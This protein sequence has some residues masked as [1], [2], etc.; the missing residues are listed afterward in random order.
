MSELHAESPAW[1]PLG[2]GVLFIF[3]FYLL[4]VLWWCFE[5]IT[6]LKLRHIVLALEVLC[7]EKNWKSHRLHFHGLAPST[8]LH[9]FPQMT[10]MLV[11][12]TEIWCRSIVMI[13]WIAH[14]NIHPCMNSLNPNT[15]RPWK[16]LWDCCTSF[17][18]KR[19]C[20][21][22][23]EPP[24]LPRE[25]RQQ[26]GAESEYEEEAGTQGLDNSVLSVASFAEPRIKTGDFPPFIPN[27]SRFCP[28]WETA[29][30]WTHLGGLARVP[31]CCPMQIT[32]PQFP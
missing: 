14:L 18:P 25:L 32:L 3:L 21:L 28:T 17:V 23:Q 29:Q 8:H 4:I 16:T 1:L 20:C 30:H 7:P 6:F 12:V 31:V 22:W 24:L 15:K 11:I 5:G 2:W 26:Q 13:A 10:Q 27:R 9:I 19:A